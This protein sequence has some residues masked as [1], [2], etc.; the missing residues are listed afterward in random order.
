MSAFSLSIK[1]Y[2]I[3]TTKKLRRTER[4]KRGRHESSLKRKISKEAIMVVST[5]QTLNL[6][7]SSK[8]SETS[9]LN[10]IW[11]KGEK[12]KTKQN[13]KTFATTTRKI[14][15]NVWP[16][17]VHN[18]INT[19]TF[20]ITWKPFRSRKQNKTKKQKRQKKLQRSLLVKD[21]LT[22]TAKLVLD[23]NIQ[24]RMMHV[25]FIW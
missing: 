1:Q 15:P 14:N 22:G 11:E 25:S 10:E 12:K 20:L 13:P 2:I 21:S 8:S 24:K 5:N 23:I 9:L 3:R 4:D 16:Q 17:E 7:T 18:H 19:V 6:T